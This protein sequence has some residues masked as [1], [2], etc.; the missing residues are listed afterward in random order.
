[1]VSALAKMVIRL[2]ITIVQIWTLF[3]YQPD[4][5]S[6]ESSNQSS[7]FFSTCVTESVQFIRR[8]WSDFFTSLSGRLSIDALICATRCSAVPTA[9]WPLAKMSKR[10]R[11][12]VFGGTYDG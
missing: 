8:A 1:M 11:A 5:R 7:S 12:K 3:L 6:I 9:V 2:A 4:T 10:V